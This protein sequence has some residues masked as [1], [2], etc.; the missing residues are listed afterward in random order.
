[1]NASVRV[2]GLRSS[3]FAA[4]AIQAA[5][6]R[7]HPA[8]RFEQFTQTAAGAV[9]LHGQ[10]VGAYAT[11]CREDRRAAAIEIYAPDEVAI[12]LW[13]FRKQPL[14]AGAQQSRFLRVSVG[15]KVSPVAGKRVL[16]GIAPPVQVNNRPPQDAIEPTHG[17]RFGRL[18]LRGHGLEE[19]L[20]YGIPREF[21][22]AE[23]RTRERSK[24]IEILQQK[25][26][27]IGHRRTVAGDVIRL[28]P[29]RG[30]RFPHL[31]R[32]SQ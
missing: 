5:M 30:V 18:M 3:G 7:T 29:K 28:N 14:E 23:A 13:Q 9:Q 10:C 6:R 21:A 4:G 2:R 24:G 1:M 31:V 20:L 32:L 19:T 27:G 8:G 16:T 11:L 12:L 26:G 15:L 25:G 22:I 17:G